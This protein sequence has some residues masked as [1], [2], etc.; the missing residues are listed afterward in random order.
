MLI[1]LKFL[2]VSMASCEMCGYVTESL[3]RAIV[4]GT[5]L[6]LCDK[7]SK[8]GE[9]IQFRKPSEAIVNQRLA[10]RRTSRFASSSVAGFRE[11]EE[12][13]VNSLGSI[14]K[15]A[16]E[17]L[18]KNQEDVAKDL[19]EKVSVL[20]KIE[21]G[22]MEPSMQLAKKLEQYFRIQI[23]K[24][25]EKSEEEDVEKISKSSS[26]TIGDFIKIKK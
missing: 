16:R 22:S 4:E 14:V 23:V 10:Y 3:Q 20:Q 5:M 18:G 7:C 8:F 12:V 15:N 21:S 1:N 11:D 13:L 26:L 6:L 24:K 25:L 17:K 2:F 9:V 19:A